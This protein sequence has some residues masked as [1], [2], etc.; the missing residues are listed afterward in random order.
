MSISNRIRE[1][2]EK[3]SLNIKGFAEVT[4]IPYRS[5]QNYLLEER[6]PNAE[7]LIK[8]NK[9]LGVNLNWLITGNGSMFV[10]N[11]NKDSLTSDEQNLING[12]RE[13]DLQT[14]KYISLTVNAVKNI[15]NDE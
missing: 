10:E 11:L 4:S 2:L 12:F 8:M 9:T 15:E 5:V 7:A 13:C 14:Q 1:I 6:S 3:R